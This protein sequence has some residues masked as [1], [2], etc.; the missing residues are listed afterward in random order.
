MNKFICINCGESCYS[1]AK[2]K[3]MINKICPSCGGEIKEIQE[4]RI[5]E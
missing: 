3:D 2:L 5:D 4:E 1:A